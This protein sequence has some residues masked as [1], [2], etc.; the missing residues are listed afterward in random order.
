MDSWLPTCSFSSF[1]S[2]LGHLVASLEIW[3][4]NQ[5]PHPNSSE[6]ILSF[7]AKNSPNRVEFFSIRGG[8]SWNRLFLA[9]ILRSR[10]VTR[11]GAVVTRDA[12]CAMR[13]AW[14]LCHRG[15]R[16]A[17]ASTLLCPFAR[18]SLERATTSKKLLKSET[19]RFVFR[20]S[21]LLPG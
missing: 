8:P 10:V 14:C 5:A 12:W 20:R 6:S 1:A 11:R 21:N 9:L 18:D 16:H 15:Q 2:A 19:N 3:F 7:T 4:F 13:D 17:H